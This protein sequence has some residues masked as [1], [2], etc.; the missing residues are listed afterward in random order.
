MRFPRSAG[1]CAGPS[2]A[3][4]G[5]PA[6]SSRVPASGVSC[7][8]LRLPQRGTPDW[9][10]KVKH[11]LISNLGP[12]SHRLCGPHPGGAVPGRPE[13]PGRTVSGL[14]WLPEAPC[15]WLTAP[16]PASQP[17]AQPGPSLTVT[18]PPPCHSV[19]CPLGEALRSSWAV[20]AV[21][22]WLLSRVG[23]LL[24]S[25][26]TPG[27]RLCSR[28]LPGLAPCGSLRQPFPCGDCEFPWAPD[29]GQYR[30]VWV[31]RAGKGLSQG[32]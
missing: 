18:L 30:L 14:S 11:A 6:P 29:H 16:S 3:G 12:G 25:P 20:R 10:P 8:V 26:L 28:P 15:P 22:A 13:A 27:S 32:P 23:D 2:P 19:L 9:R 21:C 4:H 1:E 17:A 7:R 5:A 24:L 31:W